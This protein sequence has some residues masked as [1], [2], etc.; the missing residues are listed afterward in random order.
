[1]HGNSW[2]L[3]PYARSMIMRYAMQVT[4]QV[5]TVVVGINHTLKGDTSWTQIPKTSDC[6][7]MV[8]KDHKLYFLNK[9]GSFKIFDFSGD[10]PQQT[11]EWSVMME[12]YELGPPTPCNSW[13][14]RATKLV[15]T[16]TGKVLKVE[17][18]WRESPRTW[19]FRVFESMLLDQGITVPTNDTD[20]FIRNSI[21]FT[22]NAGS[23]DYIFIFNLE[24]QKTEL[25]H[26][27][28]SSFYSVQ[29]SKAQWFVP[30]FMH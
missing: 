20:G 12:I 21:Y 10:T 24:T 15:V 3:A 1:M 11:F 5:C 7:H 14:I 28:D 23:F 22:A 8:Y 26:T 2:K 18:M 16:V 17:K 9:T 27:F 13:T 25:L 6:F 4:K 19:S 30:G 29:S